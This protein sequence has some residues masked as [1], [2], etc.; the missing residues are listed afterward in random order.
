MARRPLDDAPEVEVLS[1]SE[2]RAWLAANHRQPG[3]VWLV[4]HKRS[5][6]DRY[7]PYEDIVQEC[8]AH[9]WIDSLARARDEHRSMLWISPRK[10]GSNWS[11]VNKAHVERLEA[12]D[13]MAE[14]GRAAVERAK[15]DGTWTALDG[16]EAL[17][18]PPD[19]AAALE[20]DLRVVWDGWPR[21]VRRGALEILLNAKRPATRAAKVA[22]IAEAATKG[23]RPFQWGRA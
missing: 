8:L 20:G 13:L 10:P 14:A 9:G 21:S 16:V 23:E 19:L 12:Q 18:V 7:L 3:G 6:G 17:D 4:T 1:R 22:A 11:R 2:L 5:G 15:A